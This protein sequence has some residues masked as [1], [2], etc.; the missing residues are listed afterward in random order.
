MLE[1]GSA[2]VEPPDWGRSQLPSNDFE[3]T[4]PGCATTIFS[5]D[6][7]NVGLG[8]ERWLLSSRGL[9][10]VSF[11]DFDYDIPGRDAPARVRQES[12]RQG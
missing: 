11:F 1:I 12:P 4:S 2:P 6:G 7:L 9:W 8:R 3:S 5:R 10:P